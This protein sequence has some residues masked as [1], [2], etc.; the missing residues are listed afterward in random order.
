MKP[1]AKLYGENKGQKGICGMRIA[2]CDDERLDREL[3]VSSLNDIEKERKYKF[4]IEIYDGGKQ[5][6]DALKGAEWDALF[7]DIDMPEVNGMQIAD[8]VHEKFPYIK[9]IFVTNRADLVFDTIR[10][11]PFRFIQ[12]NNLKK[13]LCEAVIALHQK[14]TDE[15]FLF[16]FKNGN[17]LEKIQ[18]RD[19]R[20]IESQKHNLEI[21]HG[22]DITKVRGKIS[23]YEDKLISYGF[24]RIHKGFIVNMKYIKML[25]S[26]FVILD[27]NTEFA[28]GAKYT[29]EVKDRYADYIRRY[30]HGVV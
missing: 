22:D 8:S 5:L 2:I 19:I 7:L 12:K 21:V 20:Y 6:L 26:K 13:E 30:L 24:V 27:D 25:N 11:C 4:D 9:I 3:I 18:I 10:F 14:I 29:T 28:I 16:Q 15:T 1:H 17:H 23:E